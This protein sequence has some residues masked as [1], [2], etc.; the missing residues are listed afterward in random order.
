MSDA[1]NTSEDKVKCN[2]KSFG[3]PKSAANSQS[4]SHHFR[5]NEGAIVVVGC[6]PRHA[7]INRIDFIMYGSVSFCS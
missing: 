7:N 3:I 1:D 5:P 2:D 6:Q 4:I